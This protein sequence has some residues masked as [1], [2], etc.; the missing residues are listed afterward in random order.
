MARRPGLTAIRQASQQYEH[1]SATVV[2]GHAVAELL[3]C[4]LDETAGGVPIH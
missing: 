2:D 1:S 3:D 4:V